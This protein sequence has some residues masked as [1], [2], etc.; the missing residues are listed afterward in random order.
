LLE[1]VDQPCPDERLE[2][3]RRAVVQ[4]NAH[5]FGE[6]VRRCL[7]DR[8]L[9]PGFLRRLAER[10]GL[11]VPPPSPEGP[12]L[13]PHAST[14]ALPKARPL[15]NLIGSAARATRSVVKTSLGMD[16]AT[17]E[18]VEARLE[19]CRQCPGGH[20]TWKNGDVH[21]CGPMLA[22]MKGQGEGT[23][24]CILRRKARDLTETCPFGWWPEP[25]IGTPL[26]PE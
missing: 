8:V 13:T 9:P 17:D 11:S 18:Q 1:R 7:A 26:D 25:P 2:R 24:G 4:R 19:V 21:T 15:A 16:R 3:L 6:H 10:H 20:A 22:S 12:S 5:A 14:A 23:C